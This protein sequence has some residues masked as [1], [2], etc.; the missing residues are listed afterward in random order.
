M[1]KLTP[2]LSVLLSCVGVIRSQFQEVQAVQIWLFFL[3]LILLVMLSY[4]QP[5]FDCQIFSYIPDSILCSYGCTSRTY[6]CLKFPFRTPC[7]IWYP[8]FITSLPSLSSHSFR[9]SFRN[10]VLLN[11][12]FH[13]AVGN[14]IFLFLH[15]PYSGTFGN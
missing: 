11:F 3:V 8:A 12:Q 5:I 9:N 4:V 15:T 13:L 1:H 14:V 7:N 6:L 10:Y 2:L